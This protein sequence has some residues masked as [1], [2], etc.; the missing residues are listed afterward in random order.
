[1]TGSFVARPHLEQVALSIPDIEVET[2]K[3]GQVYQFSLMSRQLRNLR[4]RLPQERALGS[5]GKVLALESVHLAGGRPFA[6]EQRVIDI[7]TVPKALAQSFTDVAP[8][9][10]LLRNVPWTRVEHCISAV[11]AN[12]AQAE[13][14][15]VDDGAACLVIDRHT[16]RGDQP[17][18]YVRQLFLGGSYDL[19]ARF[20]PRMR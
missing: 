8:G 13:R 16:W 5:T 3:R 19:I 14:L 4:Q 9:S 1:M 6:L 20:A 7:T 18:T 11:N 15:Q 10:W 12:A 2:T 17:V